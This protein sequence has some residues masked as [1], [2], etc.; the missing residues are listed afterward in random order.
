MEKNFAFVWTFVF[1]VTIVTL[2]LAAFNRQG[3]DSYHI[4][5]SNTIAFL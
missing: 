3:L 2:H 5:S 1:P 4:T